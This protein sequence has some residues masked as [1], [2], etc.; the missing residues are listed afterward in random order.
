MTSGAPDYKETKRLHY[1]FLLVL[2][3]TLLVSP[4]AVSAQVNASQNSITLSPEI[5]LT[6]EDTLSIYDIL[7]STPDL[8][9]Q[10]ATAFGRS[11]PD[12]IYW[13]KIDLADHKALLNTE[14]AWVLA[15]GSYEDATLY[16]QTT[17]GIEELRFGYLA[18][19]A[20]QKRTL[21][22]SNVPFKV[23]EL[24]QGGYI[25]LRLRKLTA[26]RNIGSQRVTITRKSVVDKNNGEVFLRLLEGRIPALVFAGLV[27]IVLLFS[28]SAY[29]IQKR[30]EYLFYSFY[31]FALLVYFARRPFGLDDS[32]FGQIPLVEYMVHQE[33][34][35]LINLCYTLF[36]KHFLATQKDYPK[37]DKVINGV[38]ITLGLFIAVDTFL[39]YAY[40]FGLHLLMMDIQR[41]FMAT[42]GILGAIY[43]L[44]RRKSNLVF[45]IVI[46]SFS[47][48]IGALATLFLVDNSYMLLGS[49]IE[50]FVFTLGLGYKSR[51][52]LMDNARIQ[53]EVLQLEM[54][55]LRAQMN[56][57]FIFNS[58]GSI[59]HLIRRD[60]KKDALQY[61]S[62]F[63]QLLRQILDSSNHSTIS[64]QEE[65]DLLKNYIELESL[66]FDG[67]FTYELKVDE[68]LDVYNLEIPIL[69]VQPHVE[70]AIL[71][72]L[73]PKKG[74]AR[75]KIHFA[76]RDN[77]ILCT[78]EDNGIGRQKSADLKSSRGVTH[79]SR[80]LSI[81]ADRVSNLHG[82][83]SDQ[84]LIQITDIVT[85]QSEAAGTRVSILIP[86]D[87]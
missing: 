4:A 26:F 50:I 59:Q 46:G 32:L 1:V 60:Q 20:G 65:I 14:A 7:E 70:N 13:M 39:I 78:V 79:Q 9:F 84:Q 67:R 85:E 69:L 51:S 42:F 64:L 5:F 31:L 37:L 24:V 43:L 71:H 41:Y 53:Q 76:D 33:F 34:Q 30:R 12:H 56:P 57:H 77:Q 19:M 73:L 27:I 61:L 75:L 47:Y 55:A 66:R 29:I 83:E 52:V 3:I 28:I 80:G 22:D 2:C 62:K 18:P 11:H 8:R 86:K 82:K 17:H 44:V 21:I 48:T 63:S 54:K 68:S 81:V 38:A 16:H 15:P 58:L 49:A 23:A 6:T 25:Y 74:E 40:E 45:F 87:E 36:A 72:G 35:V 10:P